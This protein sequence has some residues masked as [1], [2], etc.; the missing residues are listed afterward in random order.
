MSLNY[1]YPNQAVH[2]LR[3]NLSEED[4]SRLDRIVQ[5]S[6][7]ECTAEELE[8]YSDWLYDEIAAQLQ[9]H[10]GVITLQ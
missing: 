1:V 5:G 4:W 7:E 6:E 3:L 9:T 10:E 2:P 8:A